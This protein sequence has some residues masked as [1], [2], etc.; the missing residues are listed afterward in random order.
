MHEDFPVNIRFK[1]EM[2]TEN[3]FVRLCGYPAV[4][5]RMNSRIQQ[6]VAYKALDICVA[7]LIVFKFFY[8]WAGNYKLVKNS[9]VFS[10]CILLAILGKRPD[11]VG[12]K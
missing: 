6:I 8:C 12:R 11:E 2:H 5:I 1:T 4:Y 3:F 10:L 7:G 9:P